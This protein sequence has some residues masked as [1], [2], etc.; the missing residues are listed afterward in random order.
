MAPTPHRIAQTSTELKK[1]YKKN[2]GLVSER[3]RKQLARELELNQRAAQA[4]E[5]EERRK[6]AAKRRKEKETKEAAAR[7]QLGVGLATQLIGYSHT[8]AQLKNGME[9]FLGIKKKKDEEKRNKET[10]LDR[11]LEETIAAIESEPYNNDNN[12]NTEQKASP[13][14]W[15]D[16]DVDD[17]SLLEIHDM[18]VLK[19][20]EECVPN[21]RP[22]PAPTSYTPLA[23]PLPP[24]PPKSDLARENLEFTRTHGPINKSVEAALDKLPGPIIELLSQD[25][26][27]TILEWNPAVGLLHKLNPVGLPPHRLRIK[28]GCVVTLLKDLNT[29][30]RLSKNHHLQILRLENDQLECLILD[31]PLRGTQT[32]LRR[33]PFQAKYR[34]QHP[35]ERTQF[36][37]CIALDLIQVQPSSSTQSRMPPTVSLRKPVPPVPQTKSP[38]TVYP[39]FKLPGLPAS[40]CGSP[41]TLNTA[42]A[43]KRLQP[44][45][46]LASDCWDDFF[47]SST[48]ISREI[49]CDA[50]PQISETISILGATSTNDDLPPICTQDLDFSLDDLDDD[51]DDTASGQTNSHPAIV[52][53]KKSSTPIPEKLASRQTQGTSANIP[54]R[55]SIVANSSRPLSSTKKIAGKC[56]NPGPFATGLEIELSKLRPSQLPKSMFEPQAKRKATVAPP[57]VHAP[58]TKRPCI[59][60]PR[61]SFS[62]ETASFKA[63]NTSFSDFLMS[64]QDAAA[65]FD[66][67]DNLSFG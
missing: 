28:V 62:L 23:Q 14:D 58:P 45:S 54:A 39:G 4:R 19:T 38:A 21:P 9:A 26:S 6:A 59:A 29:S 56:K 66:D 22:Q 7:K 2:G 12:D 42:S 50:K 15:V 64:T 53:P 63:R 61:T 44:I 25:A 43:G 32:T 65:F 31:G 51:P 60:T 41:V 24:N 20:A 67:D 33:V 11:L 10:E 40:N 47:E 48:Q 36:P 13:E 52:T 18:M 49:Y 30:N 8:Q 1:Q 55:S 16:D 5:A 34:N 3:Q 46:S 35:Y 57:R 27:S 17:E 37:I